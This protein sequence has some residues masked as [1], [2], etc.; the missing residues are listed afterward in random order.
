MV[1]L[2]SAIMA[3]TAV[4]APPPFDAEAVARSCATTR[5]RSSRSC[6]RSCSGCSTPA[7]RPARRCAACCSAAAPMPRALLERARAAGF[8]VCPSYGLTQACSTVTV[9]EPG[10]M[11]T[12]GRPLTGVGVAIAADGEILVSGATVNALRQP[13]HRRPR[14]PRRAGPPRGHRPQGRR[15]H[16]RRRERRAGGGR[17]RARRSTPASPRPPCSPGRTRSGARRSPPGSCPRRAPSP[18]VAALRAHCLERLARFKVP[19]AFELVDELPRTDVGQGPAHRAALACRADVALP[20]DFRRRAASAGTRRPRAGRPS[21]TTLRTSTMPVSA[22]LIDALDPQPGH[23]A[24]RARRGHGRHGAARRRARRAERRGDHLRLL[25]RDAQRRRGA[26]R[27]SSASANVRFKQID[28]ETSIDV[29]AASIDGV[30]CR[31][32]FMLMAE[33]GVALSGARRVLKPGGRAGAR[34]VGRR[35][36]TTAG[37]RCRAASSSSAACRAAADPA[38]RASSRGR[39]TARS[40]SSS[41]RRASS[42]TTSRRSTSRWTTPRPRPGGRA[43]CDSPPARDRDRRRGPRRDRGGQGGGDRRRGVVRRAGGDRADPRAHVGGERARPSSLRAPHVLRRRRRPH[44]PRRQD[45]RDHRL[46]LA[47]PRPR[48][49]PQGLGRRRRRRPPPRLQVRPGAKDAGLEVTDIAEAA[50]RGDIVM[51]LLPDE[52]HGEVYR[53][54]IADGISRRQAAALRPRLLDPL[55]RGRAARRR[56]RRAR[57]AQGPGPPRPPPVHRGLAACRV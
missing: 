28:A 9:A 19:K 5:S 11:E 30:L 33:P 39:P 4:L 51:V 42:S 20:D 34:R 15:D 26:A 18:A 35:R 50:S 54:Q 49:Q 27:R 13:A 14:P 7:P 46:R 22:W 56:R 53:E 47:G 31:W 21:A 43:R 52:K 16:H 1:F 3:T 24:A 10:D 37:A 8:P 29:P 12:A 36:R 25:R 55:R 57:R 6:R 44:P 48:A 17:G 38:R 32:G 40:P 23:D 2:R 41:R 45:R